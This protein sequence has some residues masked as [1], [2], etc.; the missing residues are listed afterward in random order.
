[1]GKTAWAALE[2]IPAI[3]P[4]T[5]PASSAGIF[6]AFLLLAGPFDDCVAQTVEATALER[7]ISQLSGELEQ[8]A[9]RLQAVTAK[10][11]ADLGAMQQLEASEA[12]VK[13]EAAAIDAQKP[14]VEAL[15]HRKVPKSEVAAAGA[16]CDA[17]LIPF[18]NR[19]KAHN[20]AIQ[21]L[22]AQMQAVI[23]RMQSDVNDVQQLQSRR[24][25]INQQLASL[26]AQLQARQSA[27]PASRAGSPIKQKD[28]TA[29]PKSAPCNGA[30]TSNGCE[31]AN[32]PP[33]NKP[34]SVTIG[35]QPVRSQP[36]STASNNSTGGDRNVPTPCQ[37]LT[38][39]YGCRPT[40]GASMPLRRSLA[41]PQPTR[42]MR[43]V[44]PAR[45]DA[46]YQLADGAG[47]LPA[48][49]PNREPLVA[50]AE[51]RL[52]DSGA[53]YSPKELMC[54][55]P[56]TGED[57]K[58]IDLPLRW[59]MEDIP[60]AAIRAGLCPDQ[61]EGD[62]LDACVK[63][64]YG[65]AV[66]WAEPD[67]AGMCRG[68]NAPGYDEAE[69]A[70]RKFVTA[71]TRQMN[72]PM[73]GIVQAPPPSTWESYGEYCFPKGRKAAKRRLRD[74]LRD[75][76]GAAADDGAEPKPAPSRQASAEPPASASDVPTPPVPTDDAYTN[77]MK[78]LNG[79]SGGQNNG[80][81]G[82]ALP[83]WNDSQADA[84]IKRLN[85]QVAAAQ[86][87]ADAINKCVANGGG[88]P[89]ACAKVVDALSGT[90]LQ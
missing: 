65:K 41:G 77:Y 71:W 2:R 44:P 90:P 1:M 82:P 23:Q 70:R 73:T 64:N 46:Y 52:A 35:N 79:N 57:P 34:T 10:S 29:S 16:R 47:N 39:P 58:L 68:A 27:A 31:P 60:E 22:S 24:D 72:D 6:A 45:A 55:Q 40:G 80:N 84:E 15:C 28:A 49:T 12:G 48:D 42:S 38:G 81:L 43:S 59:H 8:N 7:Q 89:E 86:R 87:R 69:C 17:V 54:L 25:E 50:A 20:A 30:V 33:P 51:R 32:T 18:N 36:V 13:A 66:I 88:T 37:D 85:E 62:A 14:S 56:D 26:R 74:I 19:V 21:R 5:L 67:L 3:A 78:S 9:A 53:P 4:R 83:G 76:L 11:T 61:P 63:Q 75:S